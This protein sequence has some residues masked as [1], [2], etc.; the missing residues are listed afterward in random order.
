GCIMDDASNLPQSENTA[1][2]DA[3]SSPSTCNEVETQETRQSRLAR[4]L[5]DYQNKSPEEVA[6]ILQQLQ[7]IEEQYTQNQ[8]DLRHLLSEHAR[9]RTSI[10]YDQE[11]YAN[12]IKG[13]PSTI[14]LDMISA[15]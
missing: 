9:L 12:R 14:D 11:S 2:N 8:A 15:E 4:S 6:A 13:I 5:K 1:L 10:I 3:E 7:E